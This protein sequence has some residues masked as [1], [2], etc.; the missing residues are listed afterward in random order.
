[1]TP[2]RFRSSSVRDALAKAR[3][4]LG[5]AALVRGT[6]LLPASGW[7]G[8]LGGREVEVS[9]FV[10]ARV[11]ENRRST[12]VE[13]AHGAHNAS[14]DARGRVVDGLVARLIATGLDR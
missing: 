11:S 4:A 3:E 13:T 5:P 10:G 1:M 7:R 8:W 14:Q 9:A 6:R 2:Q 12:T